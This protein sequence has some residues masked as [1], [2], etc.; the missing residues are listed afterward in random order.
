MTTPAALRAQAQAHVAAGHIEEARACY[1]QALALDPWDQATHLALTQLDWSN[2]TRDEVAQEMA[3]LRALPREQITLTAL[4]VMRRA[5]PAR[6]YRLMDMIHEASREMLEA[7]RAEQVARQAAFM[8][9]KQRQN[10]EVQ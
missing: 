9:D 6:Y 1:H 7:D 10:N 2:A 8:A 5:D 4:R 3:E